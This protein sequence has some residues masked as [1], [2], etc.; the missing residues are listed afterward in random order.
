[1][2]IPE[3]QR[4][5]IVSWLML[6]V[7]LIGVALRL[8]AYTSNTSLYLDEILLSRNILDL[9]TRHLL[10]QPLLFDQV[11]PRGFLLAEKLAV[12]VFGPN[13]L[14]LRL[15]PFVCAVAAM[16]LFWRLAQRMLAGCAPLLAAFLFAIGVPLIRF[17][18]DVKQYETD[19]LAATG[20]LLLAVAL[21]QRH[22]SAKH[23]LLAGITGFV[24]AWFSQS[25]VLVMIGLGVGLA[26]E[27]LIARDQ[28]SARLLAITVPLWA[29]ASVVAVLTGLRSMEPG[30]REYMHEFWNG[31]FLPLPLKWSTALLWFWERCT[32]LFSDA[33]LLRYRWP[34][35]FVLI[36]LFGV[37]ALWKRSRIGALLALGPCVVCLAASVAHQYPFRGRLVVWLLP[38]I[39]LFLA[40]GID[41]IRSTTGRLHPS[42]GGVLTALLLVLPV[43]AFVQAHPPYEIEHHR[44]LLSY[45]QQHRRS[46]DMV[47]TLQVQQVGTSFYGP[48]YGLLPGDWIAGMCDKND[49]RAYLRDVDRFRGVRR[50]WV[51]SGSGRPLRPIH[52]AVRNYLAMI[53]VRREFVSYPS[54][55][56]DSVRLELYDLSNPNRLSGVTADVFPVPTMP[57]DPHPSCRP[58]TTLDF[59]HEY[60]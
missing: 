60:H 30:T 38:V 43:L 57:A 5:R 29:A 11:A 10:I 32:T 36:A 50:L 53:G 21:C 31:G 56:L 52:T 46:G 1:M 16:V 20:L 2:S 22:A 23:L 41:W 47:Y 6:F 8:W 51:L 15:F 59:G 27:W 55:T 17:G 34:A 28:K 12:A 4:P 26:I 9:S 19:V 33:T 7:V 3:T 49:V 14:A 13:E 42:L 58:F 45:L 37:A 44:D 54:L 39:L 25:S 35:A 48:R 24:V 18:A 40:A